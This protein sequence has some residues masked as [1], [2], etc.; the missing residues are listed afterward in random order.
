[1]IFFFFFLL[2]SHAFDVYFSMEFLQ[3]H[4]Q[5]LQEHFFSKHAGIL[6]FVCV[7]IITIHIPEVFRDA[8]QAMSHIIADQIRMTRTVPETW[9][10]V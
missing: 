7:S 6:F 4:W 1:M 5:G 2:C 10:R 3:M 9:S 8:N